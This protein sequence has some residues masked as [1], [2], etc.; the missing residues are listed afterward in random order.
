MNDYAFVSAW[1]NRLQSLA[2]LAE[3][4]RWTYRSVP[5][6]SPLPVLEAYIRHTF[7]RVCEQHKICESEEFSCFNTGLLTPNQEEVFGLFQVSDRFDPSQPLCSTNRKWFLTKWITSSDR[8]LTEFMEVPRLPTYWEDP[9]ETVFNPYLHVQVNFDHIICEN[10][11]RFPVELGGNLGSNG[12]PLEPDSEED[13]EESE[14]SD[15]ENAEEADIA[16]PLATRNALEG[17]MKHSIRLALRNHRVAVPQFHGNAIQLLLPL[18]LRDPNRPDLVLTLARQGDW[19]RATTIIYPD[20]AYQH[21]RLLCRPN[22]EWL[23]GFRSDL[24]TDC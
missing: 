12:V 4:E 6:V 24:A 1:E 22:S 23:G 15:S 10:L 8:R 13:V 18:Y 2:R 16:V 17:A 19:Y 11:N 9:A 7:E 14:D 20:W 3:P 5:D 21:A